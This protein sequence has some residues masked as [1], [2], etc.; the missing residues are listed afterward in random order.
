MTTQRLVSIIT[1]VLII[2]IILPITLSLWLAHRQAHELFDQQLNNYAAR[3]M[4]RSERVKH[5]TRTAL[6]EV[7]RFRARP[8][9]WRICV[10]CK[11]CPIFINTCRAC[12]S[13]KTRSTLRPVG[14]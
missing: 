9:A 2:L 3:V 8:V 14:Q 7:S 6:E 12:F 4:A 11:R 5:Q 13:L 10:S 1:G